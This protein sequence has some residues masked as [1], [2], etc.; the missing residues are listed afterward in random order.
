MKQTF[1]ALTLLFCISINGQS[2]TG[3]KKEKIKYLFS[4]MHQDSLIS[5]TNEAMSLSMVTQ[6]AGIF[7]DSIYTKGGINY[8][9]KFAKIMQKSMEASKEY[10]KKLINEDMVDI[11]DKYFTIVDIEDFITFYKSKSGQKML[12]KLPEITTDMMTALT[13]KYQPIMQQSIM[14]EVEEM[15]KDMPKQ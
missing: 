10:T 4:L 8:P 12:D 15:M 7:K 3:P 13:V 6:M 5:K 11:Y 1:L 14:K 2:Q 9:D